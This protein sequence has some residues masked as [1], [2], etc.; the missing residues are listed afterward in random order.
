MNKYSLLR[1]YNNSNMVMGEN[2]SKTKEESIKYFQK[3]F[4]SAMIDETG[5]ARHADD[6]HGL[7]FTFC[8]AEHFNNGI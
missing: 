5:Y 6:E 3:A 7:H 8:V 2:V 1:L 4:P